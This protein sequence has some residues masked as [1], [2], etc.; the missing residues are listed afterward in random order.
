MQAFLA[1]IY[2]QKIA[3]IASLTGNGF[4]AAI[5]FLLIAVFFVIAISRP[6][7]FIWET[8]LVFV[9][10]TIYFSAAENSH[11]LIVGILL[12]LTTY[13]DLILG[14]VKPLRFVIYTGWSLIWIVLFADVYINLFGY[15]SIWRIVIMA[16][17]MIAVL[18]LMIKKFQF[19]LRSQIT[20]QE[21]ILQQ[22]PIM[23]LI[24]VFPIFGLLY[25]A[26]W[27]G[28]AILDY[29]IYQSIIILVVSIL[30]GVS[31]Q[32]LPESI[33]DWI[34]KFLSRIVR[35]IQQ[36]SRLIFSRIESATLYILRSLGDIFRTENSIY[37]VLGALFFILIIVVEN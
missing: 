12:V 36:I 10:G 23:T 7:E 6:D 33:Q 31:I 20:Q 25:M 34:R 8:L 29:P 27:S 5:V 9:S 15:I 2:L 4:T 21:N 14:L 32:F 18:S 11:L 35:A 22:L 26:T 3:P 24:G 37:L 17:L 19:W 13:Q 1:A 16:I 30:I 28:I